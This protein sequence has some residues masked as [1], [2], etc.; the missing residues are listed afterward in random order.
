MSA[1]RNLSRPR[2]QSQSKTK[3]NN[4]LRVNSLGEETGAGR[5]AS[6]ERKPELSNIPC[7]R[8]GT[9]CSKF[10]VRVSLAEGHNIAERLGVSWQEWRLNST[11]PRW[12]GSESLLICHRDGACIYLKRSANSQCLCSIHSFKPSSCSQWQSDLAKSECR[13]GLKSAWG[14]TIDG[15]GDFS[16]PARNLRRFQ[17][18]LKSLHS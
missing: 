3:N 8:C 5:S 13:D 7:L 10:Q 16:G 6:H 1:R 15:Y 17:H 18:F 9:C 2:K 4:N 14:L 12:P 11:D